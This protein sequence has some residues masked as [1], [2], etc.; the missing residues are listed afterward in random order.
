MEENLISKYVQLNVLKETFNQEDFK[1]V[2]IIMKTGADYT[3]GLKYA[4]ASNRKD[5]F[6]FFL[7]NKIKQDYNGGI[8]LIQA[9]ANNSVDIIKAILNKGIN[10]NSTE[11]HFK[12]PLKLALNIGNKEVIEA[13]FK[14]KIP[15][16]IED[17]A[18]IK[19]FDLFKKVTEFAS[20]LLDDSQKSSL[21]NLT[22][23]NKDTEKFKHLLEKGYVASKDSFEKA[24]DT[25]ND[26][27]IN[28]LLE[29]G[30][31]I[32]DAGILKLNLAKDFMIL[33]LLLDNDKIDT[34]SCLKFS[35]MA[36]NSETSK[37]CLDKLFSNKKDDEKKEVSLID[38]F[39]NGDIMA[40]I[41][42]FFEKKDKDDLPLKIA[43]KV[44]KS[45]KDK[46]EC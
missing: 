33:K 16:L 7:D 21:L 44:L 2:R 38:V 18:N 11:A 13:L 25:K 43:K 10:L 9:I 32:S 6:D 8:F 5:I 15:F 4:I 35:L 40:Y 24:I 28:D 19:D 37:Y 23:E 34:K 22:I 29:K 17:V 36:N 41:N 42:S 45:K 20:P 3:E 31:D 39:D 14:H 26:L 12:N 30:T 46:N 27:I 1:K